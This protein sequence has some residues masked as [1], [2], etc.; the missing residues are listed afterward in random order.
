MTSRSALA[1]R[2]DGNSQIGSGHIMR[3][4]A[5]ARAANTMGY[6]ALFFVSDEESSRMLQIQGFESKVLGGDYRS[7]GEEDALLLANAAKGAG[8]AGLLVDSYAASD[9]FLVVLHKHC[10]CV[11]IGIGY[12]DDEYRFEGGFS[13]EPSR[14]PVDALVNYGLAASLESYQGAYAGSAAE[15][16]I[17]PTYAPVREEFSK[18]IFEPKDLVSSILVTTGSTNP[19]NV[20]ERL[21]SCCAEATPMA[22]I[23]VIVG[24]NAQFENEDSCESR[25]VFHHNPRD[26]RSLM[27]SSDLVVSAGGTTLYEL[28]TLGVPTIAVP[29]T[30]NQLANVSGWRKLGMG[31]SL[32]SVEW[33]S[34]ELVALIRSLVDDAGARRILSSKMRETCDGKGAMRVAKAILSK[35]ATYDASVLS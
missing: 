26:M 29:I 2:V 33:G 24:A 18:A 28:A 17:G 8:V 31:Y 27:L 32:Q 19:A 5:I 21:A 35:D 4:C 16:L 23:H 3:C 13:P 6:E 15:L 30:E 1:I 9:E 12:I 10:H 22:S 11:G 25:F 34:D 14:L 20:L 7:F